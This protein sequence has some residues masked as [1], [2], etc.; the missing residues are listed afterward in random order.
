M[1]IGHVQKEGP[2]FENGP[3]FENGSISCLKRDS[4]LDSKLGWNWE[5]CQ[6]YKGPIKVQRG[7]ITISENEPNVIKEMIFEI[8]Q[9]LHVIWLWPLLKNEQLSRGAKYIVKKK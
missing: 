2:L 5:I 8:S 4:W 9:C 3:K 6:W 1:E 7:V